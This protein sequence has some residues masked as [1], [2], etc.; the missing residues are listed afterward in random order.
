MPAMAQPACP[1]VISVP[2][3]SPTG[4]AAASSQSTDETHLSIALAAHTL[5]LACVILAGSET[6][7]QQ[8][9]DEASRELI[10]LGGF[11]LAPLANPQMTLDQLLCQLMPIWRAISEHHCR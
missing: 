2:L 7:V 10:T 11:W 8:M 1:P 5:W 6:V 9:T 3:T 4:S